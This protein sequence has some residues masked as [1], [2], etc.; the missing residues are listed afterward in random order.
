MGGAVSDPGGPRRACWPTITALSPRLVPR[1][2][3]GWR[4]AFK[5]REIVES[6][7]C[8]SGDHWQDWLATECPAL[9]IRGLNSRVTTQ[10]ALEQM[11]SR[12]PNTLLKV[13]DGGHVVHADNLEG[14]VDAVK[15]F[16]RKA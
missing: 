2:P 11:T 15:E 3:A 1:N 10:A 9:L 5:P 12:R 8:L 7:R 4:L 13:L 16:L 14:F 6:G